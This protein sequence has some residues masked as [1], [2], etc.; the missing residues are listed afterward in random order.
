MG[1]ALEFTLCVGLDDSKG[2]FVSRGIADHMSDRD[3]ILEL[4]SIFPRPGIETSIRIPGSL[5]LS[6]H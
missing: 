6:A 1:C 3:V 5:F 4:E 2:H